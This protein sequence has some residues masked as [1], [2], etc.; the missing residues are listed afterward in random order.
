MF[1]KIF[2]ALLILFLI[3]LLNQ[4]LIFTGSTLHKWVQEAQIPTIFVGIY[5][6]AAQALTGILLY[7]WIFKKEVRKLGFQVKNPK[8]LG[9]YFLSFALVWITLIALYVIIAYLFLPNLWHSMTSA[10]LPQRGDMIAT[11]LFESFFPGFGE[12]ILFRGFIIN[13]L[14]LLIFTNYEKSETAKAGIVILSSFYFATAHIYF[15]L[16]PF[17]ITHI[18]A[19]QLITALGCGAFYAIVYLKTNSL[20]VPFLAHNFSNTTST[21]CGYLLAGL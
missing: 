13:L 11:L 2:Y 20:L 19:Q 16:S 6:Q 3:Q 12:E 21:L 15:S 1:K 14:G 8:T 10:Q 7:Q 17:Q 5:Q 4:F 9:K 18:D